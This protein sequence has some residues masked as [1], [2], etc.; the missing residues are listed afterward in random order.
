MLTL[1]TKINLE[2]EFKW[3]AHGMSKKAMG[4]I[5]K[6]TTCMCNTLLRTCLCRHC[7][8]TT[9]KSLM[10]NFYRE[11]NQVNEEI[12]FPIL[13]LN[14]VLR[15]ST[16]GEFAYIWQS[17]WD[18]IIA[19]KIEGTRIPFTREVFASAA[20]AAAATATAT[21]WNGS[22]LQDF[23]KTGTRALS[24]VLAAAWALF[25]TFQYPEGSDNYQKNVWY[26]SVEQIILRIKKQFKLPIPSLILYITYEFTQI[27]SEE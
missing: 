10:S 1:Q 25:W 12:L 15:N 2:S 3:R 26:L 24:S 5:I 16:P 18:E 22:G 14:M 4:L 27:P 23:R 19:I 6:T 11:Y 8:T 7:S 20:A 9:W 21:E 17:K 13:Y